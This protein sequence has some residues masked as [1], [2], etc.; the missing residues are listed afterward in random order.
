MP[1]PTLTLAALALA[2][3]VGCGSRGEPLTAEQEAE[4]RALVAKSQSKSQERAKLA[5]ELNA[6]FKKSGDLEKRQ[7]LAVKGAAACNVNAQGAAFDLAAFKRR[8]GRRAALRRSGDLG[9]QSCE[10]YTLKVT[11]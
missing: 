5:Q 1:H 2:A 3:L 6:S 8:P 11:E 10:A 9:R 4:H 7:G